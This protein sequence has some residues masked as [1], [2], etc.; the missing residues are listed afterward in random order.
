MKRETSA[1]IE[2]R[3]SW[4]VDWWKVYDLLDDDG[5]DWKERRMYCLNNKIDVFGASC[6]SINKYVRNWEYLQVFFASIWG[7]REVI[8]LIVVFRE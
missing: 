7:N 6:R 8:N 3:F 4:F 1:S 2:Y 5:N